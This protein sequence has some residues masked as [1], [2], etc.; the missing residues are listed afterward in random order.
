MRGEKREG[1]SLECEESTG[2]LAIVPLLTLLG[3]GCKREKGEAEEEVTL[4]PDDIKRSS[5]NFKLF[6]IISVGEGAKE[7]AIVGEGAGGADVAEDSV[8]VIAPS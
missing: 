6:E 8:S 7:G 4:S 2:F 1:G 5:E 3:E